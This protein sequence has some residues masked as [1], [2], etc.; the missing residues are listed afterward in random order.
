MTV[1]SHFWLGRYRL[2]TVLLAMALEQLNAIACS[3]ARSVLDSVFETTGFRT[4]AEVSCEYLGEV[5]LITAL[6]SRKRRKRDTVPQRA[7][8]A[9]L[10]QVKFGESVAFLYVQGRCDNVLGRGVSFPKTSLAA[11]SATCLTSKIHDVVEEMTFDNDVQVEGVFLGAPKYLLLYKSSKASHLP[12]SICQLTS[13]C[14][15]VVVFLCAPVSENEWYVSEANFAVEGEHM[16]DENL[17][18]LADLSCESVGP[19]SEEASRKA[20]LLCQ[21]S[22][23]YPEAVGSVISLGAMRAWLLRSRAGNFKAAT[24][25]VADFF[26]SFPFDWQISEKR[27]SQRS[28]FYLWVW[29]WQNDKS[30]W[31]FA[32]RRQALHNALKKDR[33]VSLP[34][35]LRRYLDTLRAEEV[36]RRG[37]AQTEA[38]NRIESD[39]LRQLRTEAASKILRGGCAEDTIAKLVELGADLDL[40]AVS[41]E[42]PLLNLCAFCGSLSNLQYLLEHKASANAE[43]VYGYTALHAACGRG[44]IRMMTAL[45]SAGADPMYTSSTN[46][47][48]AA[49]ARLYCSVDKLEDVRRTLKKYDYFE[50]D[51]ERYLW[52]HRKMQNRRDV[53]WRFEQEDIEYGPL[54][55]R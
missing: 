32:G 27:P 8:L 55:G 10:F 22:R 23:R 49:E 54:P 50:D 3:S 12:G 48:P 15:V 7:Q 47:S 11:L 13:A 40:N 18:L 24:A 25:D 34:A 51:R 36:K 44:E 5:N 9:F 35:P 46:V 30:V 38:E 26:E 41:P 20:L 52:E 21:A 39:T 45:L 29:R 37:R 6:I 4:S 14:G 42:K 43:S 28:V 2:V 16:F 31:H 33:E 53:I 1:L 17:L 19:W